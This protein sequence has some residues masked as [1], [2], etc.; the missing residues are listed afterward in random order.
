MLFQ[1]GDKIKWFCNC[2]KEE[3]NNTKKQNMNLKAQVKLLTDKID[4][5]TLQNKNN[6]NH[7]TMST[8]VNKIVKTTKSEMLPNNHNNMKKIHAE[9][10]IGIDRKNRNTNLETRNNITQTS[11]TAETEPLQ[12][13][14]SDSSINNSGNINSLELPENENVR[15]YMKRELTSFQ[16]DVVESFADLKKELI[17][18][19]KNEFN[20]KIKKIS[21]NTDADKNILQPNVRNEQDRQNNLVIYN[22]AESSKEDPKECEKFDAGIVNYIFYNG[23]QVENYN[24]KKILRLGKKN[25]NPD[26]NNKPRPVLVKL[27]NSQEKWNIIRNAKNL[28]YAEEEMKQISITPDYNKEDQEKQKKL[29]KDLKEK[30]RNGEHDWHIRNGQLVYQGNQAQNF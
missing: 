8:P 24:I 27:T 21:K 12:I 23:I 6:T 19:I 30:R 7:P 22:I 4:A 5:L 29:I 2:C 20:R 15:E 1:I 18:E 28:K 26:E 3:E 16:N 25:E 17:E 11:R 10:P 13:N 14:D 9:S